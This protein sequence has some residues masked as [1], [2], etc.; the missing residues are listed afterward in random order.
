MSLLSFHWM[1]SNFRILANRKRAI[2]MNVTIGLHQVSIHLIVYKIVYRIFATLV[3]SYV[4]L[5]MVPSILKIQ[6]SRNKISIKGISTIL[7]SKS[8]F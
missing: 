2:A 6:I 5:N 1:S 8:D 7:L 3:P 4:V